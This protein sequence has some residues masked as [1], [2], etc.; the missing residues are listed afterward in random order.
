MKF[1]FMSF[2]CPDLSL[3][4]LL[5]LAESL[6]YDAVE[7]RVAASHAHGIEAD[8]DRPGRNAAKE[9]SRQAGIPFACIAT[10][11]QYADPA[12]RPKQ[13]DDTLRYI[14]LAADV[15]APRIRV[16]GGTIPEGIC[17][18]ADVEGLSGALRAV[19]DHAADRNVAVCLETHDHWCDPADVAAVMEAV[20]HPAIRVNWDIMHPV[21]VAKVTMEDAFQA[22]RGWVSHVHCHDGVTR[23]GKLEMVPIGEG[24]IDHATAVRL[25]QGLPY[26]G[27]VSGEWI[28]WEPYDV[29]L[30]RE[31]ATLKTLAGEG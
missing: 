13:I 6:G 1:S 25:L 31:L 3:D 20:S 21:R 2:S 30:P 22:L 11:C 18:E 4:E 27:Y 17:R 29:H 15:G 9:K 16:F 5:G 19:A 26:E 10:S 12:S 14:D 7:P 8:L 24:E 28:N 23:D